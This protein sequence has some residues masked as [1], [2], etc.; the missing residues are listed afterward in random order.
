MICLKIMIISNKYGSTIHLHHPKTIVAYNIHTSKFVQDRVNVQAGS[1]CSL[2]KGI[3]FDIKDRE[4][5]CRLQK[6][7]CLS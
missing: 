6:V 4:K 7:N 3:Q 1:N 5:Q 2:L